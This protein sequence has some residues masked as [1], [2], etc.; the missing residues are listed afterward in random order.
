MS[1]FPCLGCV[2]PWRA[3]HTMSGHGGAAQLTEHLLAGRMCSRVVQKS[4]K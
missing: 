1:C 3:A 4:L 2:C